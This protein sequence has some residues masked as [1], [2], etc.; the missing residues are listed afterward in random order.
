MNDIA[1]VKA[2]YDEWL[3]VANLSMPPSLACAEHQFRFEDA[4][5][6]IKLPETP[7]DVVAGLAATA[8]VG[9]MMVGAQTPR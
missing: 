6:T 3:R 8:A 4:S 5:V 1:S 2:R 7:A 9:L